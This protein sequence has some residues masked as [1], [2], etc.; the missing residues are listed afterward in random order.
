MVKSLRP[1]SDM[2]NVSSVVKG[3]WFES[4]LVLYGMKKESCAAER[5]VYIDIVSDPIHS[6]NDV[7]WASYL[8]KYR[9]R[10][11]ALSIN[12]I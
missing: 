4:K 8:R 1:T 10:P 12:S 11:S 9:D 7:V 3:M 5:R 6:A 2:M